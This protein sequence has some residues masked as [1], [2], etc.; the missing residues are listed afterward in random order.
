[1]ENNNNNNN[2]KVQTK[3]AT[4][5]RYKQKLQPSTL[6]QQYLPLSLPG[7]G[8]KTAAPSLFLT[9]PKTTRICTS[10]RSGSI[11]LVV[12]VVVVLVPC[13]SCG[14]NTRAIGYSP[15]TSGSSPSASGRSASA[16]RS[17]TNA[18]G[19]SSSTYY[20]EPPPHTRNKSWSPVVAF[21]TLTRRCCL[22]TLL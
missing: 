1:M 2:N 19:S 22:Y 18:S 9:P 14:A 11:V 21:W 5:T 15:N 10:S 6:S 17:S 12:L 13:G 8:S 3:T 7:G 16:S 20:I 4:T